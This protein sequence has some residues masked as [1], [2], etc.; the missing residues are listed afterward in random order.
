M[1]D[2]LKNF[3]RILTLA[4]VDAK[5]NEQMCIKLMEEVGELAEVVNH[6]N[7]WLPHKTLKE[8]AFGEAADVIQCTLTLLRKLYPDL[9]HT[10]V[11]AQLSEHLELKSNKWE[12]V[13]VRKTPKTPEPHIVI[14]HTNGDGHWSKHAR[15]V[16][17][18]DLQ[19]G[20]IDD[21][22]EFGE[23]RVVFDTDTW[24]TKLH[25]L[26]Y[27]DRKFIDELRTYLY[28]VGLVGIDA[29][30]SEQGMQGRNFVSFD[31]GK[32][33]IDSWERKFPGSISEILE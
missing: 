24:D 18:I 16:G 31:I 10:E 5:G 27:T 4:D 2:F 11:L 26:I 19:I 20:Y 21:D 22:L 14:I 23:L 13:M 33:F 1:T 29:E 9:S 7:G 25:G 32:S 28:S 30:Y 6:Q 8:S 12:S 3:N 15:P 17:I